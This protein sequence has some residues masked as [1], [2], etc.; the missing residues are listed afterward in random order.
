MNDEAIVAAIEAGKLHAYV[1]DFPSARL[2]GHAGVIALPHI[3]A[4]TGEAE[5][6]CAVMV[7]EQLRDYFEDGNVRNSVNFP[8][9]VIPRNEG[10]R[11][12]LV[13][14]NVPNMLG[15]IS[16]TLANAGLNIIDMLNKSR[17]EIAYTIADVEDPIPVSVMRELA[18]IEGV[19]VAR[20]I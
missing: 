2:A 4:S 13:N 14:A 15:Q 10:S 19:I 7:A 20:S 9:V 12:A 6:N 16:T 5:D 3:G 18:D 17:G 1:C 8:E 11:V